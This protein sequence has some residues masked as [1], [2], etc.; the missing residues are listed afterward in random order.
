MQLELGLSD[1]FLNYPYNTYIHLLI[2]LSRMTSIWRF[3]H[4]YGF[5]I[6]GWEHKLQSTR[7]NDLNIMESF[8]KKGLSKDKMAILNKCRIYLQVQS[9]SDISNASGTCITKEAL[10]GSRDK[11]RTSIFTWRN[12]RRPPL[13]DWYE[14]KEAILTTFCSSD[15]HP[16][17]TI[18]LGPWTSASTQT[19]AWYYDERTETLYKKMIT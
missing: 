15:I 4:T 8:V 16:K 19:W 18:P 3:L 6:R 7:R 11:H 17:L 9:L 5:Q 1:L 13:R 12:T 10:N 14:W 2:T